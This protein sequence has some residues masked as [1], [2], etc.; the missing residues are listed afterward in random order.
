MLTS[1]QK[2]DARRFAG[3]PH[4]GDTPLD[5]TRDF[6]YSWVSPGVIQTLEH[7]LNNM[8]SDEES[9]LINKYLTVLN[10][11]EDAVVSATDNLDTDQAAVWVHNKNEVADRA[12]LFKR[13]RMD[14]CQ[15]LGIKPC[16]A[17]NNSTKLV[18]G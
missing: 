15:F 17:L 16:D 2:A 3:Y 4:I 18:R 13:K 14:M 5:D 7:R 10:D 1:L 6:A 12:S 8:S 11:L 9:I